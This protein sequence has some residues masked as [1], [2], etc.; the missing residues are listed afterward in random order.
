MITDIVQDVVSDIVFDLLGDSSGGVIPP[1]VSFDWADYTRLGHWDATDA[2]TI[3]E[4]SGKVTQIDDLSGNGFDALQAASTYQPVVEAGGVRFTGDVLTSAAE[5]ST[6]HNKD[7]TVFTVVEINAAWVAGK[8]IFGTGYGGTASILLGTRNA[9]SNQYRF[10]RAGDSVQFNFAEGS[11]YTLNSPVIIASSLLAATANIEI[12]GAAATM[13]DTTTSY[14]AFGGPFC[15]GT[16]YDFDNYSY[17]HD[18]FLLK[19]IVIVEEVDST[20]ISEINTYLA[21]KHGVTL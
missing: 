15:L 5:A 11:E 9:A 18:N 12:D 21:S 14:T 17:A 7:F 2:S 19:E 13:T 4:S 20:S 16:G 3:T 10:G 1:P 6:I 8:N